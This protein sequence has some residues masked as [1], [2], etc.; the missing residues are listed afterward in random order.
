MKHILAVLLMGIPLL[1]LTSGTMAE[2]SQGKQKVVYHVNS[3]DPKLEKAALRNVQNHINAVGAENLDLKVVLHGDGLALLLYPE[4]KE[5]T[6]MKAANATEEMQ[7]RVAGL[8]QQGVQFQICANT[9]KGRKIN[10]E[11][12]LYDFSTADVVASGV[13]QLAIL[14]GQGYAYIK[15]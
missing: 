1:G 12:D 4:A 15:P 2:Q 8:K 10:A 5:H 3:D 9:L 11:E 6:K 7:A 13:A 14:Q